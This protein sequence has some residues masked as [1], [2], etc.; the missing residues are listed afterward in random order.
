MSLP[1]FLAGVADPGERIEL[2]AEDSRHAAGALRL[3]PGDRITS[4]DG[5][6]ELVVCRVL[7]A[8]RDRVVAEVE[9]RTA[10]PLPAPR[11]RVL[12]APPK[13][14]R[15]TWAVQKLTEV[16]VDD[17]VL[18]EATRSVRR[19]SGE[20]AEKA[21]RR[22]DA[23]AREA[24]K[25]SRQRFLTRVSGPVSWGDAVE[26]AL[27]LG[28]LVVLWEGAELGLTQVLPAEAPEVLSLAIGPE[29]GIPEGD[30][31]AAAEA[32]AILAGL[33]PTLLRTETAALAAAVLGLTRY[34]RWDGPAA[35]AGLDSPQ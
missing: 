27:S 33:G 9:E 23:V 29:G 19:W 35:Q 30:A 21:R 22:V 15:L 26:E 18:V 2:D 31:R 17:L 11:V 25:Q 10:E 5:T 3:G 12:L 34:G 14:E 1:H 13:G 4:S 8:D 6:G 20:R 24:A 16:G 28:S 32:G 7:R